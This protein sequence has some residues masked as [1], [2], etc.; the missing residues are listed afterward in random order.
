[1]MSRHWV[2]CVCMAAL[3]G[4]LCVSP[5]L[6]QTPGVLYT[7]D[8]SYG[9]AVGP[10]V[11]GWYSDAG[12][13]TLDNDTDGALTITESA[14]A[15][16]DGFY[17][18]DGWN[19]INEGNGG[20]NFGGLDLTGLSAIQFTIGHSST[21]TLGGALYMQVQ[22]GG[23]VQQNMD[24]A[25]GAPQTYTFDLSSL[26]EDDISWIN[27]IG[28]Q[29]WGHDWADGGA[30]ATWTISDVSSVGPALTERYLSPHDIGDMDGAYVDFDEAAISGATPGAQDGL[31][32]VL[33]DTSDSGALRWIDQGG[34]PGAAIEW[35]NGRATGAKDW[36]TFPADVSN[37]QFVD[38]RIRAADL[39][40]SGA[41]VTIPV[42]FYAQTTNNWSWYD[43]PAQDVPVDGDYHILTFPISSFGD[44]DQMM[45]HGIN[46][47]DHTAN[48]DI[49]VD[50]IRFY[51]VPEP[52]SVVL[53][54]MGC[55]GLAGLA[56][57]RS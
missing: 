9:D 52:A 32:M 55:L 46:L 41:D 23:W 11:E 14:A 2:M 49:R 24:F 39:P 13:I 30:A 42:Q 15:A 4:L 54:V 33:N 19:A 53:L 50:Y 22:S 45:T 51:S 6:A 10:S 20:A 31:T 26:V 35:G 56:R 43:A 18:N 27:T 48:T 8:Q 5:A 28:L 25:P 57:R 38:V 37:Y 16:T 12:N 29:V 36:G 47:G 21:A 1:M 34:G 44:M 3:L 17:L 40:T 7:W